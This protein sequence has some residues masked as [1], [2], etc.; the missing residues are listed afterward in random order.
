MA[1][2]AV[3]MAIACAPCAW[4]M[5]RSSSVGSARML[6]GMSLA[7]ALLHGALLLGAGAALGHAGMGD[8]RMGHTRMS[9]TGMSHAGMGD[10]RPSPA[11]S[12]TSVGAASSGSLDG[13]LAMLA[14][15]GADFTAAMLAASWIRY[16]GGGEHRHQPL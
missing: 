4:G 14:V 5:W 9:H 16:R 15:M 6:V 2:A 12:S 8:A 13:D 11:P 7:M 3:V 10:S 1:V